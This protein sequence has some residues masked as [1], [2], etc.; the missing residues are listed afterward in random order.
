MYKRKGLVGAFLIAMSFIL[1]SCSI[2]EDAENVV[3]E[4]TT[5]KPSGEIILLKDQFNPGEEIR[6]A[7]TLD[8]DTLSSGTMKLMNTDSEQN[9]AGVNNNAENNTGNAGEE[10]TFNKNIGVLTFT[11]PSEPGKY[12]LSM[13]TKDLDGNSNTG[14]DEITS[15][16][17]EVID[18]NAQT[19]TLDADME[20]SKESYSPGETITVNYTAPSTWDNTAWIGI[21]PSIVEHGNERENFKN[22]LSHKNLSGPKG[23][24]TFTAPEQPGVYDLRM[25]NTDKDGMEVEDIRII[26]K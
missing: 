23:T 12:E 15:V 6:L 17:I 21:V 10:K 20:I 14:M 1:V 11:A 16:T 2:K 7:Y 5:D 8:S 13:H 3:Q 4:I 9:A 18:P 26:V 19:R 24:V 22:K 25:H